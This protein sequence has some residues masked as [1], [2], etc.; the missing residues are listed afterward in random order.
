MFGARDA[1][2]FRKYNT[3]IFPCLTVFCL[4]C[5]MKLYGN[6]VV[7][8]LTN[9]F[10]NYALGSTTSNENLLIISVYIFVYMRS[11]KVFKPVNAYEQQLRYKNKLGKAHSDI[12]FI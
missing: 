5:N 7:A 10:Q 3:R 6:A 9:G 4:N 8:S 2:Q 1:G 11:R 12:F